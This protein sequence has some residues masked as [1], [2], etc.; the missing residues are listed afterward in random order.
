LHLEAVGCLAPGEASRPASVAALIGSRKPYWPHLRLMYAVLEDAVSIV[1]FGGV[2][3]S[4]CL[5]RETQNWFL[6]D[7]AHWVFSFRNVC[8][9]LDLDVDRLRTR[10]APWLTLR[11]TRK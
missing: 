8:E 6:A 10:L 1:V 9:A 2:R 11:S 4:G 5:R 7:D 3:T